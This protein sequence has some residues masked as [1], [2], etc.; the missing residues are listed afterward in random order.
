MFGWGMKAVTWRSS[1]RS[2]RRAG[3]CSST[4]ASRGVLRRALEGAVNVP[5]GQLADRLG[6]FDARADTYVICQSG[7]R[8]ATAVGL[9]KLAGFEN[10]TA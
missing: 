1:R 6:K 8:S 2:S 9:L 3:R 7:H 4:S 10:A 5:L